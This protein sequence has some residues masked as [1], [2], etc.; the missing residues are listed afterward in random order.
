MPDT[1][2]GLQVSRDGLAQAFE[3]LPCRNSRL[4]FGCGQK[5]E[6]DL[7]QQFEERNDAI[8]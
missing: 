4:G 2:F 7:H 8:I 5:E 1:G 3:L 6:L